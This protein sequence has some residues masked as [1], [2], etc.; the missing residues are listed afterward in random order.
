MSEAMRAVANKAST[1]F[2]WRKRDNGEDFVSL[3]DGRPD[4]LQDA[5]R[6]AHGDM[7]PDDRIYRLC[8]EACEAIGDWAGEE[9]G[10]IWAESQVNAYTADRLRWAL[11]HLDRLALAEEEYEATG[12]PSDGTVSVCDILATGQA[13]EASR[14]FEAMWNALAA[15]VEE[16]GEPAS[17]A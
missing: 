5:V 9:D 7:L 4:W 16:E 13:A 11:S 14:V 1:Y 8:S 12:Y 2:V 6:E 15:R 3:A 10:N 17:D